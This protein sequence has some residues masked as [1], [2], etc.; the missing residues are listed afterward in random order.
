MVRSPRYAFRP[1]E[2]SRA[3]PSGGA[4]FGEHAPPKLSQSTAVGAPRTS[5]QIPEPDKERLCA[6]GAQ[7]LRAA[8]ANAQPLTLAVLQVHDLPEVELVFGRAVA[9]QVIDSVIAELSRAAGR[10]GLVV[11]SGPDAFGLLAPGRG[12]EAA[13]AALAAR[14]GKPCTIELDTDQG[15][16]L[17]LPDLRVHELQAGES[18]RHEYERLCEAMVLAR[19][20]QERYCESVRKERESHT[21]TMGLPA[22]LDPRRDS[23]PCYP[24]LPPTIRMPL[25]QH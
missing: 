20:L 14:F 19:G 10:K 7:L 6:A 21:P 1:S 11:R 9:E 17:L 15:E 5:L 18:V 8:L 13:V 23:V 12:A 22:V 2:P 3:L 4:L 25:R 24:A 16:I